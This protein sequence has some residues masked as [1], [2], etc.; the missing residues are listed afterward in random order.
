MRSAFKSIG[1]AFRRLLSR[2]ERIRLWFAER[3][4]VVLHRDYQREM[5]EARKRG[6]EDTG[7]IASKYSFEEDY[8]SEELEN[9]RTESVL[10]RARALRVS[11]PPRPR[12]GNPMSATPETE[13]DEN[14][15]LGNTMRQWTLTSVGEQRLR[16]A[17]REEDKVRRE[18]RMSYL[19]AFTGLV[20]VV[21]G[22]Y[23]VFTARIATDQK[24]LSRLDHMPKIVV[25][26]DGQRLVVENTGA[27]VRE[28]LRVDR[29]VFFDVKPCVEP[30]DRPAPLV[31]YVV[32]DYYRDLL[33]GDFEGSQKQTYGLAEPTSG[34]LV[35]KVSGALQNSLPPR[36]LR[37]QGIE[38][39]VSV[40]VVYRDW[41]GT[42]I[43]ECYWGEAPAGGG[44]TLEPISRK[45]W[46]RFVAIADSVRGEGRTLLATTKSPDDAAQRVLRESIAA[47]RK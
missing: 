21:V 19:T 9:I 45:K 26:A 12:N 15:Y 6:E 43:E 42:K 8:A 31:R 3:D 14:W 23:G 1:R 20:G 5:A 44:P 11:V 2:S 22:L 35:G 10:R 7:E 28:W 17:I 36:G 38:T 32:D 34:M 39:G 46:K 27:R 29:Q 30:C 13:G 16:Q 4:I 41:V 33:E 18:V 47:A 40:R 25:S 24:E 37:W